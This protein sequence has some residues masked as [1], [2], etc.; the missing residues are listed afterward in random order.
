MS[1]RS[2]LLLHFDLVTQLSMIQIVK[3]WGH[4]WGFS[5]HHVRPARRGSHL[6]D[7]GWGATVTL[8]LLSGIFSGIKAQ[9]GQDCGL[10]LGPVHMRW[11]SLPEMVALHDV[12]HWQDTASFV[13][14]S[15]PLVGATA[16]G[17][18]LEKGDK[19]WQ[20]SRPPSPRH[21]SLDRARG[22]LNLVTS[23]YTSYC[24]SQHVR[25]T[26][27]IHQNYNFM[28]SNQYK[29]SWPLRVS[30]RDTGTSQ[31]NQ[32]MK[33]VTK[34]HDLRKLHTK[35]IHLRTFG[36]NLEVIVNSFILYK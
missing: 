26:R 2:W 20:I 19:P 32:A 5:I 29:L 27:K 21:V 31:Y 36:K 11:G 18:L 25:L 15:D 14:G 30:F 34:I 13:F 7:V 9:S 16:V 3:Q 33:L 23:N 10:C 35:K 4:N 1:W 12:G 22:K 8:D 17:V 24:S 28:F 6:M